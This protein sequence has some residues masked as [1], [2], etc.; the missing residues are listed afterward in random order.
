MIQFPLQYIGLLVLFTGFLFVLKLLVVSPSNNK[1]WKLQY[2]LLP[3]IKEESNSIFI[4]NIRDFR[5]A[6][7]GSI[8]QKKYLEKSYKLEDLKSTWFG[9]SH[10]AGYGMAHVFLSFEFSDQQY[11]VAS[12]EARLTKSD[13]NYHPVKGLFRQ[14]TKTV[15][16]ATEQDVIGLRTHIRSETVYLYK[17]QL[18]Q[19][20]QSRLLLK[21][22]AMTQ[23]LT[24][25]PAFYNTFMDNCITGLLAQ[26]NRFRSWISWL[27]YRII[28]PGYSDRLGHEMGLIENSEVLAKVREKAFINPSSIALEDPLFSLKIRQ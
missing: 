28:L 19:S 23:K 14:Y 9:I 16:L 10:F 24:T 11:L 27:D 8:V 25:E 5:Y 17:F 3:T 15:V 2:Q 22:L 18:S 7:D 1:K 12:I 4:K 6:K 21:Y 20:Q 13:I 26:T